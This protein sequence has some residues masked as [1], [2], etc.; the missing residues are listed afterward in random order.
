MLI[1]EALPYPDSKLISNLQVLGKVEDSWKW[2]KPISVWQFGK[3]GFW[4]M[5]V[6]VT[7]I[8]C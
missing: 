8:S 1:G 2:H 6:F 4:Q 5:E 3:E 7:E